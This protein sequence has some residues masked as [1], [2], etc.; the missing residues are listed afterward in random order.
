MLDTSQESGCDSG[1]RLAQRAPSGGSRR[2]RSWLLLGA[3][4]LLAGGALFAW[5][6]GP[7]KRPAE[8]PLDGELIVVVRSAEG[9]KDNL[10]V[11]E[12]GALPVRAGESM[13]LEVHFNQPAFT[14]LVW[15]DCDGQAIPLYPWNYDSIEVKD[16]NEP[17]PA[18]R[19][20]KVVISP[21]LGTGWKFGQRGGLETALLLARRTPLSE[22]TR[23]GSLLGSLPPAK[24][25]L[26]D[27]V[28]VLGL[29]GGA[30][31]V[32]TL[33]ALNRGSEADA[34]TADEPLQALL[35]RL[36]DHFELIRAVRFA[37]EGD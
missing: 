8:V 12:P 34:G 16:L 7:L 9:A 2:R 27:E 10:R 29:G 31:S 5:W 20:A 18:R 30:D 15:V 17:P 35:V 14:Y 4:A 22:G 11:E 28:T 6:R 25:R 21:T 37:H 23:L 26:R 3:L 36:R 33:L 24:L 32:S 19:P 13:S 1:G